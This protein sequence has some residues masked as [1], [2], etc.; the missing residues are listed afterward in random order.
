MGK[1][2]LGRVRG[3]DGGFGNVRSVYLNDGGLPGVSVEMSGPDTAKD[4]DFTFRNLV[5]DPMTGSEIEQLVAG[6]VVQSSNVV[7]G[8]VMTQ[9]WAA[10]KR[11]FAPKGHEHD[12]ADI[13]SG[14]FGAERIKS[15]AVTEA[16]LADDAV[17]ADKLADGSVGIDHLD[18]EMR[19]DWE[20]LLQTAHVSV[21]NFDVYRC[22]KTVTLT[23][24]FDASIQANTYNE[25]GTLPAG[26]TPARSMY[27][28]V[29]SG[30]SMGRLYV[31]SNGRVALYSFVA[32]H[33]TQGTVSFPIP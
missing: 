2:N 22:A 33:Q 25:L 17:T 5:N 6:E 1:I 3:N 26:L 27:F 29:E 28:A 23:W 16:K 9:I 10:I 7:N 8:S 19:E 18:I 32:S 20:S 15:G 21:G 14:E 11:L 30:G 24:Y 13:E 12:A 31:G 4:V